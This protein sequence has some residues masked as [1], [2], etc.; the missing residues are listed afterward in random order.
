MTGLRS[1]LIVVV[2]SCEKGN[3]KRTRPQKYK[4][5]HAFKN[6]LHDTSHTTKQ[7]NS[8]QVCNV[9]ER[10]KKIIEWKIKYKKYKPLKSPASCT[11]CNQKTVK[12][13]YHTICGPCAKSANVCPKCGVVGEVMEPRPTEDDQIKLDSEMQTLLKKLPERKR[14]TFL[15]FMN[16]GL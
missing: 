7:I 2:M 1:L 9:C 13:A 3:T 4:N 11:K 6:N 15:R 8:I 10:C 14:R 5:S 16:K 12:R